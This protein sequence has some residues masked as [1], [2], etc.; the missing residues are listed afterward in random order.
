MTGC[1]VFE[2]VVRRLQHRLDA[3]ASKAYSFPFGTAQ[4][5]DSRLAATLQWARF[6][7]IL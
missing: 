1:V 2:V 6:S 7:Q 3:D 5:L 4:A